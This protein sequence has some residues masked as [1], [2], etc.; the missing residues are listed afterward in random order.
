MNPLPPDQAEPIRFAP[1]AKGPGES[2]GL[3]TDTERSLLRKG[4]NRRQSICFRLGRL[5]LGSKTPLNRRP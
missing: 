1:K 3:F 2:P 5:R 4:M